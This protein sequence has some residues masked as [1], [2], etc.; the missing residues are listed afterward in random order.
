[1][2]TNS[3]SERSNKKFGILKK[4]LGIIFGV[5]ILV[6]LYIIYGRSKEDQE[7][8]LNM[9]ETEQQQ[10]E[11]M[12]EYLSGIN[13][14][15]SSN[16]E[17]LAQAAVM[18]TDTEKTLKEVTNTLSGMEEQITEVEKVLNNTIIENMS[19]ST[20]F[21]KESVS[22]TKTELTNQIEEVNKNT[23]NTLSEMDTKIDTVENNITENI[24]SSTASII[25][26]MTETKE[27]L[28]KQI[29]TGNKEISNILFSM[30][31]EN[32][33]NFQQTYAKIENLQETLDQVSQNMD[34][35]Y[36]YLTALIKE[37][38]K[39]NK[40]EHED[41][42]AALLNAQEKLSE[43]IANSFE[44][45]NLR[46]DEDMKNL[47]EELNVLHNRIITTQNDL[48]DIL[49]IMEEK[50]KKHLSLIYILNKKNW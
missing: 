33:N 34:S 6:L 16:M 18:Q 24:I 27:E 42:I 25:N 38:Q 40:E 36:K 48:T 29:E 26:S 19:S 37:F 21:I 22:E 9:Y 7:S 28:V 43:Y 1:M 50:E 46:L 31:D 35:Y 3:K 8:Q 13:E 45:L 15:V 30:N 44:A 20:D 4:V 11:E 2:D 32:E 10:I 23:Q 12:T 49:N 47:M 39:E 41:I 14:S 5:S 17:H